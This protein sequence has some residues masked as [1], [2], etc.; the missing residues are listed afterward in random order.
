MS[1]RPGGS[2]GPEDV[3]A[4]F[5]EIVADLEREGL[6]AG[7]TDDSGNLDITKITEAMT[8]SDTPPG[9]PTESPEDDKLGSDWRTADVE[10][11]WTGASE[12]EEHYVPPD[13]P[14]LP[15]LRA[16]TVFGLVMILIGIFLLVAPAVIGL[17]A[18]IATPLALI[19][20]AAGIGWLVLRM[21]QGP[22]PDSGWD[23]GAQL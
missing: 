10:W 8:K 6:G 2:E 19:S 3:D 22:P 13:P 21:R 9:E 15:R 5:A 16:G 20:L 17:A 18:R 12:E 14:P 23:N 11:D 4:A 1:A 7:L